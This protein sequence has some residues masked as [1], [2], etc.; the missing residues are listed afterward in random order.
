MEEENNNQEIFQRE[1]NQEKTS[2]IKNFN[3][4]KYG[5]IIGGAIGLIIIIIIALGLIMGGPQKAVKKYISAINS[6]NAKKAIKCIDYVG[7][8]SWKWSYD[9]DDFKKEDYEEFLKN[10]K[11]VDKS[12][13]EKD[14]NKYTEILDDGFD[15]I[16][17]NSKS[18]SIKVKKIKSVKK[19]EKD[20]YAVRARIA[21]K[22]KPKD[23]YENEIDKTDT[24][25]FVVYK[26]KIINSGDLGDFLD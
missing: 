16:K 7:Y 22:I 21:L 13:I 19:L 4:K 6:L 1:V 2:F 23:K 8:D 5:P 15:D 11:E 14:M 24:I 18:F 25:T 9:V 10:Y 26:N 17:D 3:F 12:T 20:L